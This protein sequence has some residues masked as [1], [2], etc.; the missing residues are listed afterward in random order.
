[1]KQVKKI[2]VPLAFS[3]F[4][5]GI[6]DYAV[7]LAAALSAE[8]VLFVSVVNQRDVDAVTTI[9]SLGYEV[10][11]EH[12]VNEIKKT[13]VAE[14]E[15]MLDNVDFPEEQI[16][17]LI[18]VGKPAD[19]LLKIAVREEVDMIVMGVRAKGE[20]AHAF[21]G[22]VAEKLFR[23]SPVTI[24]SYREETIAGKLRKRIMDKL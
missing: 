7:D 2:M 1:M 9:S 10:D 20:I 16:K 19:K 15:K 24:V 3:P 22:S 18:T 14:L 4:S 13:R 21:T 11:G 12:Y 8:Q 17:L 6:V 23:R 5:Q